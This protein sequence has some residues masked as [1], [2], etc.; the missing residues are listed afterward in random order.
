MNSSAVTRTSMSSAA[1]CGRPV[2]TSARTSPSMQ[3]PR[4][5]QWGK[6][7]LKPKCGKRPGWTGQSVHRSHQQRLWVLQVPTCFDLKHGQRV[8]KTFPRQGNAW[9]FTIVKCKHIGSCSCL[10]VMLK[11]VWGMWRSETTR[12]WAC[13]YEQLPFFKLESPRAILLSLY[14]T[15]RL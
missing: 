6:K 13:A 14:C 7:Q 2:R 15:L 12:G 11:V 3:N 1:A 5:L 9:V 4:P 10:A 8:I